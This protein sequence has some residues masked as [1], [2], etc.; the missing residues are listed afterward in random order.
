[1]YRQLLCLCLL[2]WTLQ[3]SAQTVRTVSNNPRIPAQY[4]QLSEAVAASAP[5]DILY[6]HPSAS[7]YGSLQL[8]KPL[9]LI[10]GGFAKRDGAY[11]GLYTQLTAIVLGP[12]ADGARLSNLSVTRIDFDPSQQPSPA[13]DNILVEYCMADVMR[14]RPSAVGMTASVTVRQCALRRTIFAY[15]WKDYG[16]DNRLQFDNNILGTVNQAGTNDGQVSDTAG[17]SGVV[18]TNNLIL[19]QFAG[20]TFGGNVPVCM[21]NM[22]NTSFTNNM[23]FG[24]GAELGTGT[25]VNCL[26]SHNLS[27]GM[28]NLNFAPSTDLGSAFNAN[29]HNTDPRFRFLSPKGLS[30]MASI[31]E[32]DLSLQ[33]NSPAK[34]AGSSSSGTTDIGLQG[35]KYP[36]DPRRPYVFP[37]IT[38]ISIENPVLDSSNGE[39]RITVEGQYPEPLK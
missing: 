11:Y 28:R 5:G 25:A 8:N 9:T 30:D 31:L 24:N 26:F 16:R 18:F 29:L 3:A 21:A 4:Q 27:S 35:G 39:I 13:F 34:G 1:M 7:S 14:F 23:F 19:P 33:D 10:G 38:R 12:D 15:G 36:F 32:S 6:L 37:T 22:H 20:I 17:G 2:L